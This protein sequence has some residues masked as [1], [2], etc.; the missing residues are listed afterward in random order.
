[1]NGNQINPQATLEYFDNGNIYRADA[2]GYANKHG[3]N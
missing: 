2:D 1:M 3:N